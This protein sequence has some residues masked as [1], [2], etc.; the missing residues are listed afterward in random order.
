MTHNDIYT[1]FMIEYD[2]ANVTS[3]YP[4]L[5]E[6]EVATVLDKAYNALIAQKITGNNVRRAGFEVDLKAITDLYPLIKSDTIILS[7]DDYISNIKQSSLPSDFFYFVNAYLTAYKGIK[8]TVRKSTV[9]YPQ[10]VNLELE[11][12]ITT[13]PRNY[14]PGTN[15]LNID[16]NSG[17]YDKGGIVFM[18]DKTDSVVEDLSNVRAPGMAFVVD[19]EAGAVGSTV[20]VPNRFGNDSIF[21]VGKVNKFNTGS[22]RKITNVVKCLG[23]DV[24]KFITPSDSKSV[25]IWPQ[26]AFENGDETAPTK[27]Y[28]LSAGDAL[29][30]SKNDEDINKL[31]YDAIENRSLPVQLV[32]HQ[33]A[34]KFF[35]TTYNMPWVKIP[36][37]FIENDHIDFVY[38][39]L[40]D[41]IDDNAKLIY[42]KKPNKFAKDL[43]SFHESVDLTYFDCEGASDATKKYYEFECNNTVAEE[44]ISLAITFAL[45][46]I[47]SQRLNS[48]LNMRGLEA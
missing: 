20:T 11:E 19:S 33:I 37:C 41:K 26:G 22:T 40:G 2:K 32:N 5:T 47:E 31:P 43:D 10:T 21:Y 15:K 45:E 23:K 8:N 9:V 4:S 42:I 44:L 36:V 7:N 38:D 13:V 30:I 34:S 35:T 16:F 46:N 28:A 12:N 6:Y 27:N 3:S 24:S 18:Y 25:V 14:L 39:I 1:K 29:K 17:L 48:K